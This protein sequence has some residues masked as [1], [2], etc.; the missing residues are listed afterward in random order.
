LGR[1]PLQIAK[2]LRLVELEVIR[3]RENKSRG[4]H[5][6]GVLGEMQSLDNRRVGDAYQHSDAAGDYGAHLIHQLDA[7]TV[8]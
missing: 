8:A 6:S 3:R 1:E 2:K 5:L 4:A 7:E